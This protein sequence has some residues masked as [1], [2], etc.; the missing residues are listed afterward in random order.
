VPLIVSVLPT[1]D[2]V[3]GPTVPE[4]A[5]ITVTLQ[6]AVLLPSAVV[7]VITALPAF[8][9]L[10]T[11]VVDTVATDELLVDQLTF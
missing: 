5:G 1:S 2:H 11:P 8:M 9:K 3:S 10:T 4:V 6:V 7:T